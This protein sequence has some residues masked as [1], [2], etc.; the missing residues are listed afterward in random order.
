MRKV[1]KHYPV[2][3][4]VLSSED[5]PSGRYYILPDGSRFKSVTT[6]LGERTDKSGLVAWREKV[7]E[8][9]ANRISRIAADRGTKVHNCAEL[10][11]KNDDTYLIK[12][13]PFVLDSFKSLGDMLDK[14]VDDIIA[15]ELPLYSKLLKTAGR[16]D[17]I[18]YYDGILSVIDFKTSKKLKE[19]KWIENYFIQ[20]TCYAMMFMQLYSIEI[21]QIVIM[22][23]VD[24]EPVQIFIKKVKDYI[25]KVIELF[26]N[27][28]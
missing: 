15:I 25:P 22:I 9:E 2:E 14:H 10:H 17:L 5:T 21:E 26:I 16:T 12:T 4:V 23:A 3:S 19:E 24:D 8:E 11:L 6:L 7:G 27:Y 20:A 18:A 28:N 13:N 1:F